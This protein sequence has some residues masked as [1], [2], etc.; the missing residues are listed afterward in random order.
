[1]GPADWPTLIQKLQ[2][3]DRSDQWLYLLV[4]A[5][6]VPKLPAG[7]MTQLVL[8]KVKTLGKPSAWVLFT[9]AEEKSVVRSS[10]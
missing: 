5:D 2:T 3:P 7:K 4:E 9:N 8:I 1:M 6:M 10:L